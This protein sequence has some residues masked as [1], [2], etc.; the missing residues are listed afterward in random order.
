MRHP[1]RSPSQRN[2]KEQPNVRTEQEIRLV[3]RVTRG[4][5]N[6]SKT[7]TMPA[8]FVA[9]VDVLCDTLEWVLGGGS[10]HTVRLMN[11]LR[12]VMT[13]TTRARKK[14]LGNGSHSRGRV[15]RL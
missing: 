2:S 11:N 7:K 8:D 4:W 15:P 6:Y 13:R 3:A 12:S 10:K 5:L 14:N 9:Q 1:L